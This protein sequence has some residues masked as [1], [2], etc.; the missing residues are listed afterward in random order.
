MVKNKWVW[1]GIVIFLGAAT[2]YYSQ[3]NQWRSVSGE[4]ATK[5]L[6]S[7]GT[8]LLQ[9]RDLT[10]LEAQ[11]Q[12]LEI[13]PDRS[14]PLTIYAFNSDRLCGVGGCLYSIY[15]QDNQ[16]LLFKLLLDPLDSQSPPIFDRSQNC[17]TV[18]QETN[19]Q[20]LAQINYCYIGDRYVQNPIIYSNNTH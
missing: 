5:L 16:Q 4:L 10:K 13:K 17:L 11:I 6:R 15:R 7:N 2:S 8:G 12:A 3:S 19:H 18:K 14:P 1:L 9:T 20:K